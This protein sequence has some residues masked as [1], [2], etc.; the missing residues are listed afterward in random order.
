MRNSA[1]R[2]RYVAPFVLVLLAAAAVVAIGLLPPGPTARALPSAGLD[3]LNVSAEVSV[4][5]LLGAE[6][7]SLAGTVTIQR[8]DPHLDSGVEVVDA[9]IIA[10]DLVGASVT[11]SIVVAESATLVSS[12][13]L[14]SLQPPPDQF[15]ASSFFDVFIVVTLPASPSSTVTRHNEVPL[16]LVPMSGGSEVSLSEW[17]PTGVKYET[18]PEPCVP[19][20]PILPQNI[21]V[22]GLSIVMGESKP[23]PTITLTPTIVPTLTVTPTPTVTPTATPTKQPEGDT[24]RDGC[25]DTRENGPDEMLGG[26][27]DYLNFWDFFDPNRDLAVG[28]LDFLAVLRHF[29]TAGD[30]ATLD[31]DGPEPP[32]GEYWVLA[33]RGGQAP[34]GDPWDELP[35]NGSIGLPDFLSVLRQFGHVCVGPVPTPMPTPTPTPTNTPGPGP[36]NVSGNDDF[37]DAW[38]ISALPFEGQQSTAGATRETDEPQPCGIIGSTVWFRFT[39][40]QSGTVVAE[41]FG[42]AFDTVLAAYIGSALDT[43]T[44][45]ECDD[46]GGPLLL[47][48]VSFPVTAGTTY[49]L[50]AGGFSGDTGHLELNVSLAP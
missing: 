21:C 23:T 13:E 34:G 31:P 37:A 18:T 29:N 42:S 39:A 7:I 14:R 6:T 26:R 36:I 25:N 9:E 20:V 41:T 22:T 48:E 32:A 50:Q 3:I 8:D 12:S 27:R 35:A 30:P 24:D 43:L 1:I 16:H 40:S 46:D 10:M 28:L 2:A 11:G 45:L 19:L 49:Y 33:D 15:P 17:P 44:L 47:S 5:S 4:T 38:V